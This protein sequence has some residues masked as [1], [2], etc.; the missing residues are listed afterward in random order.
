VIDL[1]LPV[2]GS[3]NDP[4]FRIWP[5]VW[6]IIGN[7]ITKALTSP[8]S[9]FTGGGDGAETLSTVAFETGTDTISSSAQGGLDQIAKSMREKPSLHLTIIGNAS[10]EQ[11]RDAIKRARL[12]TLVLQEAR[13]QAAEA[14]KDVTT[15]TAVPA[16]AYPDLLQTVY[17][18][19]DIKKPRNL[20]GMQKTV[21]VADMEALLMGGMTVNED[22]V[23]ELARRRSV[24]VR[25]Y[26]TARQL[27]STQLF[28]G[29]DKLVGADTAWKP[30][31]EL[32]LGNH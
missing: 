16:E 3:L 27:P 17:R 30:Q 28:L 8:F 13:R 31:A 24:A 18:R 4:Q 25:E 5:V 7:L 14:G 10:L 11:E 26:L 20:V 23:R 15:V 9:L 19:S 1:D 12:N 6:K 22:A 21:P 2:S 29:A 32:E